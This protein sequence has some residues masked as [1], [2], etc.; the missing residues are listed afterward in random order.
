VRRYVRRFARSAGL[1]DWRVAIAVPWLHDSWGIAFLGAYG[2][3]GD[4]APVKVNLPPPTTKQVIGPANSGVERPSHELSA[5]P[6]AGGPQRKRAAIRRRRLPLTTLRCRSYRS[7]RQLAFAYGV[8]L[9]PVAGR[10]GVG[11]TAPALSG[12][13]VRPEQYR[14]PRPCQLPWPRVHRQACRVPQD[15]RLGS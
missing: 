12:L 9:Q 3:F 11:V 15:S 7:F 5:T 14:N 1:T 2:A 13:A 4:D 6:S 10:E 8:H